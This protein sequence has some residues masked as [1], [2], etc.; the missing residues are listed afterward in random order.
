MPVPGKCWAGV[1]RKGCSESQELSPG[2]AADGESQLDSAPSVHILP[3][4]EGGLGVLRPRSKKAPNYLHANK[5]MGSPFPSQA[6]AGLPLFVG[7]FIN[8]RQVAFYLC[9]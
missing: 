9:V 3:K 7:H 1:Q 6:A 5:T 8:I 2:A 4:V